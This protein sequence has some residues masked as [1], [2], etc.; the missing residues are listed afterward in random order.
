MEHQWQDWINLDACTPDDDGTLNCEDS[1][2]QLFEGLYLKRLDHNPDV[3][4]SV[5]QWPEP[6]LGYSEDWDTL[7]SVSK[8]WKLSMW[9]L[10]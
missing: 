8:P 10:Y 2:Q 5:T 6:A 4:Q 1:Q 9:L 7:T 3:P